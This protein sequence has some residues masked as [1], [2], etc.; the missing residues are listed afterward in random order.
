VRAQFADEINIV[1]DENNRAGK[2]FKA[3]ISASMLGMSRWV[4]GSSIN[5][6]LGGSSS[7][8]T[9]ASRLFSPPLRRYLS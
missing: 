5:N 8:L 4:V 2:L 1:A 9:S 3:P 6:K 7:N